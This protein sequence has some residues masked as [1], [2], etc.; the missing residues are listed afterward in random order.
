MDVFDSK[1]R[2]L[3]MA[4]VGNMDTGPEILV[5]SIVHRM[6]L[7]FRK[8]VCSLPGRPDIV[9]PKHKKIIF[10]HG[11][12]WHGHTN[13]K[14]AA[15]PSSNKTFWEKKLNFNIQRDSE[16][17]KKLKKLGWNVTVIWQC[18]IRNRN[19]L[20]RKLEQFLLEIPGT[21]NGR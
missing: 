19:A 6:G 18:Q 17:L 16:N 8:N 4:A 5:R 11:C 13:C 3:I 15:R 7:R 9:L 14:R 20:I 12:F 21:G 2:S 1:K 10:V